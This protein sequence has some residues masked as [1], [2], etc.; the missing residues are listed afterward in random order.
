MTTQHSDSRWLIE[1]HCHTEWSKDSLNRIEQVQRAAQRR[2]IN[3]ILVTDHN[4][5]EG[6]LK[7]AQ[8]DPD[9][10]I[11]GEEVMTTQGELLAWF[12][13]E[14]VPARLTPEETIRRLRDQGAVISVAHPFDSVRKGAWAEENLDRIVDLVDCI[15]VFNARC[16]FDGDNLKAQ[17]YALAHHKPGTAGSDAHI[18]YEYG[19]AMMRVAPFDDAEGL[20]DAIQGGEI[21][22]RRSAWW[23]HGGSSYAKYLKRYGLKKRLW[24]GG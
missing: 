9:L 7:W 16:F 8:I 23:V 12:V 22:A 5:A 4:T 20:L 3:R 13:K 17:T 24:E 6:A 1:M 11:P 15:E 19:R 2:G 21:V 10:F 14:S 18:P